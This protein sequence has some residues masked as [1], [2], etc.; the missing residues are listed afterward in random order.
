M[1][2][3]YP[4]IFA[5]ERIGRTLVAACVG[6]ELHEIGIR[7]VSDFFEMEGWDTYY[8]GAN[9]PTESILRAISEREADVLGISATM[10]FH[11]SALRELVLTVRSRE[12]TKGVK[13]LVGGYTVK[14]SPELWKS[15]GADGF[16]PS[17]DQA[18]ATAVELLN[19]RDT[20]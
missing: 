1:S 12:E 11:R 4:H 14:A 17:A 15:I 2:R 10:P 6:G 16:S 20:G 3:L 13:I 9:T 18:V 19:K 5:T 7:T 8:L